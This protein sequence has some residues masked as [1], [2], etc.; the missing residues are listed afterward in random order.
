MQDRFA[1]G[2]YLPDVDE[3]QDWFLVNGEEQNGHTILEFTRNFKPCDPNDLP[4]KVVAIAVLANIEIAIM[5]L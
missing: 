5:Q 2:R 3:S 4:I 1:D